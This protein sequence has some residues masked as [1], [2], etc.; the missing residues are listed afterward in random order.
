MSKTIIEIEVS[1]LISLSGAMLEYRGNTESANI[2]PGPI[3]PRIDD[4]VLTPLKLADGTIC[5]GKW[6]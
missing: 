3:S 5:L 6:T 1:S 4:S 2:K